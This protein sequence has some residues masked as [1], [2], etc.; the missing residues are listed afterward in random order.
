MAIAKDRYTISKEPG[1]AFTFT[2]VGPKGTFTV[3]AGFH[4]N[5]PGSS[6][7]TFGF[8]EM[9]IDANGNIHVDDQVMLNNGDADK[10]FNTVGNQ[11]YLFLK[12]NPDA[13]VY[14]SGS[15]PA[16]TRIYRQLISRNFDEISR[17][18]KVFGLM[19]K[20]Q[21]SEFTKNTTLPYTEFLIQNNI[22]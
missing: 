13:K 7:Y 11:I 21:I 6:N 19:P 10:I 3:F 9:T 18:L 14:I 15:T 16:R 8:G 2:S 12:R 4:K 17:H 1:D 22:D 20:N 5:R